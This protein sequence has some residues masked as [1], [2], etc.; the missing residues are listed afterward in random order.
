MS[1]DALVVHGGAL[2]EE[3]LRWVYA[4]GRPGRSAALLGAVVIGTLAGAAALAR[5][6]RRR[7]AP[8]ARARAVLEID[9]A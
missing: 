7:H 4:F 9:P 3:I 2:G 5:Q 8:R 6:R 1:F